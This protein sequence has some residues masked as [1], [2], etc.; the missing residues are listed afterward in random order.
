ML[1]LLTTS[2]FTLAQTIVLQCPLVRGLLNI[3]IVPK[4][5]Q[6]DATQPER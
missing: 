3:R 1:S 2:A 5:E 6:P 4:A